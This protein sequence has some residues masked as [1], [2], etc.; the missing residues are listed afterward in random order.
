MAIKKPIALYSGKRKELASGDSLNGYTSQ[1]AD[2]SQVAN[3]NFI[4]MDATGGNRTVTLLNPAT[5]GAGNL[6]RVKKTDS[7]TNIVTVSTASGTIQGLSSYVLMV[8]ADTITFVSD[9][10]NWN[11]VSNYTPAIWATVTRALATNYTPAATR[12]MRIAI[13]VRIDLPSSASAQG[14]RIELRSDSAATP[15]TLVTQARQTQNIGGL[16]S[17]G[18]QGGLDVELTWDVPAGNQ[19]RLVSVTENGTPTYSVIVAKERPI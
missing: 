8:Q 15:T 1:S 6:V 18:L 2:Y 3:I 19:Y 7:S 16:L 4:D 14:G 13:T 11:I 10:T 17:G 5:H 12:N 9:G